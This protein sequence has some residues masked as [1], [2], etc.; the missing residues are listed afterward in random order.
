MGPCWIHPARLL[1]LQLQD[2]WLGREITF[3]E[4]APYTYATFPYRLLPMKAL[5]ALSPQREIVKLTYMLPG[6]SVGNAYFDAD[7]GLLL[8]HHALWGASK[9]FFL[10]AE[11]NFDF[12]AQAALPEDDGPHTGFKSFVSEQS[13][14]STW[15]VG[16]GSVV[17][18]SLVESRYGSEV[19]MRVLS[20]IQAPSYP[21]GNG[22][23]TM[24]DENYCFFG[25]VPVV[26][27]VNAS[28]PPTAPPELWNPF[29]DYLWWW[30]PQL[31][32]QAGTID[33]FDVSMTRATDGSLT[34]TAA[35]QPQRFFFSTL[36]FDRDGYMTAFS[37]RDPSSGLDLKPTDMFFQNLN[38]VDGLAYYRS[39][40]APGLTVHPAADFTGDFKRDILWHH[41]T[42][43]EVW[44]W[45]MQGGSRTSETYVRAVGDTNWEIRGL[46]DQN[47]DGTADLLWRNRSTGAIYFWPMNGATPLAEMYV[48]AVDPAYDIVG[49]GDYDGDRK[50]DILWRHTNGAV[51]IWL[52]DGAARLAQVYVATVD[53]GY[54]VK[55]SGDLNADHRSDIVWHHGTSGEVWAWLMDGAT[56]LSQSWVGTVADTNYQ[57]VGVDDFSGDAHAD[58]LWRH[59]TAGEVWLWT[60][61]GSTRLALAWAGTVADISY[62]IVGTGD[63]D[64]DGKADILWHHA[65][66][67][68]VWQW[69]MDGATRLSQSWVGTVA[70]VG[71]R[72]VR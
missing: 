14:G 51:W 42:R 21:A 26:T 5:F 37:A 32:P 25:Q 36:W 66:A 39:A 23:L 40:M 46:G 41:A 62:R 12:E 33:V 9:M 43:G 67:G 16:G 17:I 60:M 57:V 27:R 30:V 61:D 70:D 68:E 4:R 3:I 55:G 45:P 22:Q 53:P 52:M 8:Y 56:L 54:Q 38:G 20:S 19:E 44:L 49:T 48:G 6:F 50:S 65:T 71:Y 58:I 34:F 18:Q 63:Y 35:G 28:P 31:S 64:G 29:G 11:I 72:P 59:A 13:L 7:T 24:A 69:R 1:T 10:L 15:G 47:G 2:Y